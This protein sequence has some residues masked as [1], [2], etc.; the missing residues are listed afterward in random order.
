[1]RPSDHARQAY[2]NAYE[3][4]KAG[5]QAMV[6]SARALYVSVLS[7]AGQRQ[8]TVGHRQ[9]MIEALQ[10]LGEEGLAW[11]VTANGAKVPVDVGVRMTLRTH[12][13]AQQMAQTREIAQNAGLD[14]VE[15]NTTAKCRESHADWQGG[16]Y[17][18]SGRNPKYQKFDTACRVGDMVNGIGGYN[19][20]HHFAIWREG[21]PNR[22]SDPLE[23][24]GY[25]NEQVRQ[26]NNRQRYLERSIR[27]E[28]RKAELLEATGETEAAGIARAKIRQRQAQLRKLVGENSKVLYRQRWR[29]AVYRTDHVV[30]IKLNP[31]QK[32]VQTVAKGINTG[33]E[34]YRTIT[35]NQ[36]A[37]IADR[38]S[39]AL[40]RGGVHEKVAQMYL[41]YEGEMS[42]TKKAKGAGFY[43]PSDRTVY[44]D[45]D[46]DE[47]GRGSEAFNTWFHEFGHL[48]D[49]R[50]TGYAS[51]RYASRPKSHTSFANGF[52][53][54]IHGEINEHVTA[55]QK[56]TK[57]KY[58]EMFKNKDVE[59]L[60]NVI[61]WWHES[62]FNRLVGE[63]TSWK[64]IEKFVKKDESYKRK[65]SKDAA[66]QSFTE[67]LRKLPSLARQ[68]ISDMLEGASNGRFSAGW[69]HSKNYWTERNSVYNTK[70]AALSMEAFAEY[71]AAYMTSDESLATLQKYLPKSTAKYE[72]LVDILL[73]EDIPDA[74]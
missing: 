19:C 4:L 50:S 71:T 52:G 42:L 48:I 64:E 47:R 7:A 45:V 24:T 69:G 13:L 30:K 41:K 20:G 49:H 10:K 59:G 12:G 37:A 34:V 27:A 9:A 46:A 54:V 21:E 58:A 15:V 51:W 43:R 36:V 40:N 25:T 62:E 29:E 2:D 44:M 57:A 1:M 22:Y 33:A 70:H 11:N 28:K 23:G 26:L 5:V 39:K 35:Q 67:E 66:W 61:A 68:D 63:G 18:L 73:R 14:L 60:R 74:E 17:S 38:V 56:E 8:A 65:V 32:I 6:A 31:V 16:H 53:D 55:I 72:E 3:E